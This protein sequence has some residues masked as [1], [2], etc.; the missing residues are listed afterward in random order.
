MNREKRKRRLQA[1]PAT[2]KLETR[3]LMHTGF[4]PWGA[5]RLLDRLEAQGDHRVDA[6]YQRLSARFDRWAAR[7]PEQAK[8]SGV[9]AAPISAWPSANATGPA[10]A[11]PPAPTTSSHP[12]AGGAATSAGQP[13][14]PQTSA[15]AGGTVSP[16]G[17]IPPPI[18][19][20]DGIGWYQDCNCGGATANDA[21]PNPSAPSMERG[22]P[23]STTGPPP[24]APN[25]NSGY[26][27]NGG[28]MDSDASLITGEYL[29]EREVAAY[30]SL[31]TQ[32][33]VDLEY[34]SPL[35]DALPVVT[36]VLQTKAGG[37]SAYLTSINVS[38]TVNGNS[39]GSAITYN[40]IS[41]TDGA[42][43]LVQIQAAN[44]STYTTGIYPTVLT[45]VKN[46][47]NR[48]PVTES[49]NGTL[50]V[51]NDSSSPYGAGW[52]IGGLEQIA[53]G[54]VG[55]TLMITNGTLPPEEFTSTNGV[56]Y[57]GNA[58]DPSTLTYNSGPNT[59]TRTFT[60][61][62]VVTFNSHGQEIS[63]ADRN[64]NT[65]TFSYTGTSLTSGLSTIEDPVGLVTTFGYSSGVLSTITDPAGRVTTFT[66]SSGNLTKIV[67][68]TGATTSFGYNAVH[69]ITSE[70]DADGYTATVAYDSFGRMAS[71]T[72]LGGGTDVS[73]SPAQEVGL[74]AAGGT[75]AMVYPNEY[76]GTVTDPNTKTVTL[77]FDS[78]GEVI[79]ETDGRGNTTTITRNSNDWPAEVT[80]PLGRVTSYQYDSSG[81]ITKI[82]QP[83]GASETI[84]Y[85]GGF[86]IPTSITD[87]NGNTTTYTLDSHG[88]VTE[89][90]DPDGDNEHFTYNSAG[91]TLTYESARGYTISYAYDSL[92]R[93]TTITYPGTG[94][95]TVHFGYNSAGDVTSETDQTGDTTIFTYDNDDRLLTSQNPV[96]AGSSK[97]VSYVYDAEGNLTSITDAN[98]KTTTYTYNARNELIAV[99]DARGKTTSYAYDAEGDLASTTD[100]LKHVN[101]YTYD[102]DG[103]LITATDPLNNETTY[104]YDADNEPINVIDPRGHTTTYTY[105]NLGDETTITLPGQSV[106]TTYTYDEDGDVTEVMDQLGD[107]TVYTYNSMDWLATES[108][109]PNGSTPETTTYTY[110]GDGDLTSVTNGLGYTTSYAYDANDRLISETDPSGGGT[111]T[112]GYDAAGRLVTLTDPDSNTTTWTYDHA[113]DVAT[114]VNPMGYTTSYSYDLMGNE[115]S[116]TDADGHTVTYSYDGDYHITGETWVNPSGGSPL[117]VVT[118][119][120]DADGDMTAVSDNNASYQYTYNGDNEVTSFSDTGTSGLPQVTL[121]Y[122]HDPDGNETSVSDSLGGVVSYTYDSRNELTSQTFSGTGLSPEAVAYNYDAAGRL[123]GLARYSN[124]AETT[125]VAATS[126]TY[127]DANR[128]TGIVDKN[129]SGTTLVSYAYTYDA[130]DRVTQEVRTWD[131]GTLSDTLTYSYT[132]NNQLTGVAHTNGSFANESFNYDANGNETGTGYTTTTGNEQ[133]ASPGYSYTYDHDGNLITSTQTSTGDYWTYAYDYRDRLTGAVEK[134]SGGTVLAQVTYTYDAL[135]NRI[136][137][138]ENG[139]QTWTLY[140]R[141]APVMDFNGSGSLTMRYMWGPAGILARQTSG[142]TVSWYLADRLGTVRD[143]INNSGSIIDHVDFSAFGTVLDESNPSNGD[144]FVGF[145]GLE[146]DTVT[147]LNLA[148]EREENP[149]TGRWDSQDPL[150]FEGGDANLFEYVS[151]APTA[152]ADF[153]G[154]LAAP[155]FPIPPTLVD[156]WYRPPRLRI[157]LHDEILNATDVETGKRIGDIIAWDWD[158]TF[159][160]GKEYGGWIYFNPYDCTF[161]FRR[162]KPGTGHNIDLNNPPFVPGGFYVVGFWHTHPGPPGEANPS[163]GDREGAKKKGLPAFVVGG[164]DGGGMGV[165][166]PN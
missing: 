17:R 42:S 123:T 136:G 77:A 165:P 138:D 22:F 119:T 149:G 146:R 64:G 31:D 82:T 41:L 147:G 56:N 36:A 5:L 88:N 96:Q 126:Y 99:T 58:T 65:T 121:T 48:G 156:P 3:W 30:Q 39:Q 113:N 80:D 26:I 128:M 46:F 107:K 35:A 67:D 111:T 135:D 97:D 68:P 93:L 34:S 76:Q 143:L 66:E 118:Y 95:P 141:H 83:D 20:L 151:D 116:V 45:V 61:G 40:D 132:N 7:H 10:H 152:G 32:K 63:V 18:I 21:S 161:T 101:T 53:G 114:E 115:T 60:D 124:L 49:Y 134:T 44:A 73:I 158:P 52:T 85:A 79:A 163:P 109:Y 37:D 33:G 130:A 122:S 14:P 94:S 38:L 133:T 89:Q 148:V 23:T 155:G 145:A 92:G 59:Y 157:P 57:T 29:Q 16:D 140:D 12:A 86:G 6:L 127:D 120:Y 1:K 160:K 62:T 91:E 72:L 74:V 90:S 102:A 144:R 55:S 125:E 54:T 51:V 43:Y 9:I 166:S 137:M 8:L 98:G 159:W 139:T 47:S 162:A 105:N 70:T 150:G 19:P 108:V 13:G 100:P 25:P 153:S 112:Y 110:D 81:D 2:E 71:E 69:G 84:A 117:D 164:P 142:G 15:G 131:S 28:P 104:V 4:G 154:T 106:P 87:F 78:L 103:N 50:M 24:S 11:T 129:S 27:L 75:T